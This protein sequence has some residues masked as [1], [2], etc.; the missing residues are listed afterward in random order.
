MFSTQKVGTTA[1]TRIAKI[2]EQN[3]GEGAKMTSQR[4]AV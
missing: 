2:S 4:R 3:V 1:E